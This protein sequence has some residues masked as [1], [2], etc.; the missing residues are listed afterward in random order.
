L[1]KPKVLTQHVLSC[2]FC[3]DSAMLTKI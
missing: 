1:S 3:S 2:W